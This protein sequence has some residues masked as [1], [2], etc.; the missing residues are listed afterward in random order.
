VLNGYLDAKIGRKK[1]RKFIIKL[2]MFTVINTLE[3]K[4]LVMDDI[5]YL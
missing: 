4:H 3:W 2:K 1:M 5:N